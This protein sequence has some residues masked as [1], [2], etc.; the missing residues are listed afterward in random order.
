M[1]RAPVR[2]R[3][4]EPGGPRPRNAGRSLRNREGPSPKVGS[5]D[6]TGTSGYRSRALRVHRGSVSVPEASSGVVRLGWDPS[7]LPWGRPHRRVPRVRPGR[8]G[9][10]VVV[11]LASS[12]MRGCLVEPEVPPTR[13]VLPGKSPLPEHVGGLDALPILTGERSPS[14]LA[15]RV[16]RTRSARGM[17][18]RCPHQQSP[19]P[20]LRGGPR[21]V[22]GTSW[23]RSLG[24]RESPRK[25]SARFRSAGAGTLPRSC[26]HAA[27]RTCAPS[28]P[29][30][31]QGSFL[32]PLS[33][34]PGGSHPPAWA[35]LQS[36]GNRDWSGRASL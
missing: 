10:R 35:R 2:I 36:P 15:S 6:G 14:P 32:S 22:D 24:L 11:A 17:W 19:L 30:R 33:R 16:P 20:H 5:S 25:G 34:G 12:G 8:L 1:N 26:R 4:T 3:R 31:R 18:S 27:S 7:A 9:E 21:A 28:Q 23:C 13:S 29:P